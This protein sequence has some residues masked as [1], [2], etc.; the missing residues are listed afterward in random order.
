V[1][2]RALQG[3]AA[4]SATGTEAAEE[5]LAAACRA[6]EEPV[7]AAAAEPAGLTAPSSCAASSCAEGRGGFKKDRP[8]PTVIEFL[9]TIA[10]SFFF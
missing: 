10:A 9:N 2:G 6:D 3:V 7:V 4:T 5:E 8:A 1:A